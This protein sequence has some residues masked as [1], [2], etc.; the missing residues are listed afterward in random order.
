ME[1]NP[2]LNEIHGNIQVDSYQDYWIY[3]IKPQNWIE[4]T[5]AFFLAEEASAWIR[6]ELERFK[7]FLAES[8][9]KHSPETA[10]VAL[11]EGG[12]LRSD[13][14]SEL[15]DGV[16]EDFQESFLNVS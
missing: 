15:P 5:S 11:Q 8:M 10:M 2:M 16:W 9:A 6:K 12:E 3:K 14:M 4:E 13:T 7:D 1:I